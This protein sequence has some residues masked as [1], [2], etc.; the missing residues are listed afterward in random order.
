M[1]ELATMTIDPMVKMFDWKGGCKKSEN[2]RRQSRNRKK[3]RGRS[4]LDCKKDV[5]RVTARLQRATDN[6]QVLRLLGRLITL[7]EFVLDNITS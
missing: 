5:L 6:A 4:F 2:R 1:T 3:I 7:Q